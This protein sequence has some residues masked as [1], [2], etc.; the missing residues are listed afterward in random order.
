MNKKSGYV[1]KIKLESNDYKILDQSAAKLVQAIKRE[2]V[3]LSGVIPLPT[4]SFNFAIRRAPSIYKNSFERFGYRVHS[5]LLLINNIESVE[6]LK[7][8]G[9]V[10]IPQVIKIKVSFIKS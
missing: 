10:V 2:N 5:R 3:E 8:I 4:K 9:Q 6:S 7:F 1:V